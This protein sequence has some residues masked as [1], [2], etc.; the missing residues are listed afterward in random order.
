[1]LNHLI[2]LIGTITK[3]QNFVSLFNTALWY[4]LGFSIATG[5]YFIYTLFHK[6]GD[7]DVNNCVNSSTSQS[8]QD[9]CKRAFDNSRRVTIVLYVIFWLIELC[10]FYVSPL[11]VCMMSRLLIQL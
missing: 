8:E 3:R 2:R 5:A 11:F 7:D 1:M 10:M 6:V 9:E 4:H